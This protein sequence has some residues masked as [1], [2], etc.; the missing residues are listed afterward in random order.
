MLATTA[1]VTTA[2]LQHV[3]SPVLVYYLHLAQCTRTHNH[4]QHY[5]HM[6]ITPLAWPAFVELC[7]QP[8]TQ[9]P[10]STHLPSH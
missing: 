8:S 9:P 6:F 10:L 3:C 5:T 1:A 4:S 7:A 2:A